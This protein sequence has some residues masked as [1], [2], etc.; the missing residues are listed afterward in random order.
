MSEA[1]TKGREL[2]KKIPAGQLTVLVT[3]VTISS[4][5]RGAQLE[6]RAR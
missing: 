4:R 6:F 1:G 2:M 3:H 5:W